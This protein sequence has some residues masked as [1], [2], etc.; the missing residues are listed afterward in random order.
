[1]H[2]AI[3]SGGFLVKPHSEKYDLLVTAATD[4]YT[5]CGFKKMICISHIDDFL[6][7]HLPNCYNGKLGLEVSELKL[8]LK[9]LS[10]LDGKDSYTKGLFSTKTK[11]Q[12]TKFNKHYYEKIRKD[13]LKYIPKNTKK[14]LSVGC[15]WGITESFLIKNGIEVTGIPLDP[16]IA[17]SAKFRGVKTVSSNFEEAFHSIKDDRF[18]CI[19]MPDILHHLVNPVGI[20][21]SLNR[22]L[23]SSGSLVGSVPNF[24]KIPVRKF[25]YKYFCFRKYN[26]YNNVHL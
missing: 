18:D 21:T 23:N 16:V 14:L 9:K 6:I 5:Q 2:R 20:L 22:L 25:F 1:L 4:P 19:V 13:I 3:E 15:G 17:E 10:T 7:H 24:R 12:T 26:F 11:L 8:Q